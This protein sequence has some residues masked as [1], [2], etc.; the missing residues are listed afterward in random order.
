VIYHHLLRSKPASTLGQVLVQ[1]R[2]PYRMDTDCVERRAGQKRFVIPRPL[3]YDRPDK[4]VIR[5]QY[6]VE[7]NHCHRVSSTRSGKFDTIVQGR[8][9][10]P[11]V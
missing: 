3:H 6:V 1:R 11:P 7:N 10:V 2:W 5:I 9:I 8:N 4:S